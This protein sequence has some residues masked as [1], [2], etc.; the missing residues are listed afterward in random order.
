[1]PHPQR[2][3][4]WPSVPK[5][6]FLLLFY[7]YISDA[8]VYFPPIVNHNV[9]IS[10]CLPSALSTRMQAPRVRILCV[11]PLYPWPLEW[12]PVE[13]QYRLGCKVGIVWAG[14]QSVDSKW[15]QIWY[16]HS[17]KIGLPL[18]LPDNFRA[19]FKNKH[20][21]NN[22]LSFYSL[23]KFETPLLRLLLESSY[24]N[25]RDVQSVNT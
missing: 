14:I 7:S 23:W 19:L 13:A 20:M 2:S 24:A 9:P 25:I 6:P 22:T 11:A 17:R 5:Q 21:E 16:I 1:M 8:P 15:R 18:G 4:P 3:R 10:T 12:C